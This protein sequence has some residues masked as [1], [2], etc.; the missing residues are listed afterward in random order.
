MTGTY[1]GNNPA[2]GESED[3]LHCN[4]LQ[5]CKDRIPEQD[6]VSYHN[7]GEIRERNIVKNNM[8]NNYS[9]KKTDFTEYM[10]N[11]KLK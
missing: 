8:L 2:R 4:V 3:L 1:N 11:I 7:C 10:K 5:P 9:G 6:S